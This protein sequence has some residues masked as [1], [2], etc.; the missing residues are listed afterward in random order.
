MSVER[1]F[2]T[3]SILLRDRTGLVAFDIDPTTVGFNAP[4]GSLG[5][6]TN[7]SHYRKTGAL[8]TDWTQTDVGGGGGGG[9]TGLGL[10]RYRTETNNTPS[11]GRLQFN[12]TDVDL[13]TSLYVNVTNDGGVD[14]TNFLA[15]ITPGDLVYIQDQGDASKFIVAEV[16]EG[17]LLSGV[18]TFLLTEIESQGAAISNN[19]NV[20][21]VASHSGQDGELPFYNRAGVAEFIAIVVGQLP[22]FNRAGNPENIGIV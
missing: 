22:F 5:M 10:W 9:F 11:A 3:E 21:F 16:G 19:T 2:E 1:A 4:I 7:G 13:A 17:V 20:T 8:D 15:L 12:N 14:M 6:R 18:F